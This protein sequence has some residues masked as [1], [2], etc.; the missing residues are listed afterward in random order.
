MDQDGIEFQVGR[1]ANITLESTLLERIRGAQ[2][3][4]PKLEEMRAKVLAGGAKDFGISKSGM[5]R[6]HDRI[7]VSMDA[8]VGQEILDEVHT[9]PYSL[10]LGT[11][12]MYQ[13]LKSLYW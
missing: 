2:R 1:L 13:D 12:K 10:H 8:S 5:L 11:P 9:A 4:D 6:F 7:C 3:I